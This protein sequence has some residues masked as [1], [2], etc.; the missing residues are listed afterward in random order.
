[1]TTGQHTLLGSNLKRIQ[2]MGLIPGGGVHGEQPRHVNTDLNTADAGKANT[3]FF[4]NW[5]DRHLED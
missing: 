4:G 2:K 1:M 5:F 3:R